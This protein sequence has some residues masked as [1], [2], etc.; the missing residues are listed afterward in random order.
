MKGTQ[1]HG[2]YLCFF[3]RIYEFILFETG[4]SIHSSISFFIEEVGNFYLIL[5]SIKH[6]ITITCKCPIKQDYINDYTCKCT[7]YKYTFP[8]T[9]TRAIVEPLPILNSYVLQ[10]IMRTEKYTMYLMSVP[11]E[12]I[13]EH[14]PAP[15]WQKMFDY[16]EKWFSH[17]FRRFESIK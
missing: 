16:L 10:M 8:D 15:Y 12:L 5:T 4:L 3:K 14:L 9:K 13:E 7:H 17:S 1:H 2:D 6:W 11:D